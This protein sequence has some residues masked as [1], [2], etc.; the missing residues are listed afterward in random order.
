MI[1]FALI[2]PI[3]IA[4]L[5]GVCDLAPTTMARFKIGNATQS[6]ADLTSQ[7]GVMQA[8]DVPNL[9][10]AGADVLTPFSSANLALR[11]TNVASDGKN[12]AFVYW[13]CGQGALKPLDAQSTV[14]TPPTGLIGLD[15]NGTNSSY[16]VVESQ[17][18]YTA[19]AQYVLQ[20]PQTVLTTAYSFPR[21]SAYVGFPWDGNP[22]D[23]PTLPAATTKTS[24]V[25][26]GKLVCNYSS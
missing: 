12:R 4:L 2:A 21:V 3:L 1:E 26:M 24:S 25:T 22:D 8:A 9:F 15:A 5:L 10:A 13:S 14:A 19:P 11:I 20:G 18:V 17:Y 16:V 23:I 6:V 7:F